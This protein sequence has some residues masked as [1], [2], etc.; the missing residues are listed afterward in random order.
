MFASIIGV[1]IP[2]RQGM[3]ACEGDE[4]KRD[5]QARY[6]AGP[7]CHSALQTQTHEPVL[8]LRVNIVFIMRQTVFML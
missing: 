6:M 4:A 7:S 8:R 2:V 1:C 3:P 5:R